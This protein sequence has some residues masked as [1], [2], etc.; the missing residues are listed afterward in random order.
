MIF[1]FN[2]LCVA[3]SNFAYQFLMGSYDWSVAFQRSY[4]QIVGIGLYFMMVKIQNS[5]DKPKSNV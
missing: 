5:V 2:L 3:S 4:F 1:I